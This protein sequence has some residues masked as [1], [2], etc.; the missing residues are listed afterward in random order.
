MKAEGAHIIRSYREGDET[1]INEL[2]NRVFGKRRA[3]AEWTWKYRDNPISDPRLICLA[4]VDGGIIGQYACIPR[5]M[6]IK[7]T[8]VKVSFVADNFVVPEHRGGVRGVQWKTFRLGCENHLA[9]EY[10]CG[11]GFP[12]HEHY[13]VGKRFMKYRDF[14]NIDVF[15][16]RLNWRMSVRRRLP[17]LPSPVVSAV[18]F[19]AAV[20]GR[21][22]ISRESPVGEARTEVREISSFDDRFDAF[23]EAVKDQHG[24]IG[25]RD[26]EYLHWRYG[27]P[28]VKYEILV[29][30]ID[31]EMSGYLISTIAEEEQGRTGYIVDILVDERRETGSCLIRSALLRF[32]SEKADH[33]RCWAM[34]H[35]ALCGT[36]ERYGFVKDAAERINGVYMIFGRDVDESFIREARNWYVTMGDSDVF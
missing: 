4:E 2:F 5:R 3:L 12:N 32:F 26:R 19:L 20:A 34:G 29:S 18:G 7:D 9:N 8:T 33:A 25:V 23:W 16:R 22:R 31:G 27:K 14:G 11:L 36:L 15:R 30:E 21:Q 24:V 17:W 1:E 10:A 13:V 28:G 6:K 35:N